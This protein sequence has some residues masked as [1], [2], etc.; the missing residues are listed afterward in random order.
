MR[1]GGR[2]SASESESEREPSR[3]CAARAGTR[4]CVFVRVCVCVCERERGKMYLRMYIKYR[5]LCVV[6]VCECVCVRVC[7]R[8]RVLVCVRACVRVCARAYRCCTVQETKRCHFKSPKI[9]LRFCRR[10]SSKTLL[11]NPEPKPGAQPLH[12]NPK[13]IFF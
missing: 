8:V 1:E 6:S 3:L 9:L 2:E 5:S 13:P 12:L 7:V 10:L 4:V 11:L